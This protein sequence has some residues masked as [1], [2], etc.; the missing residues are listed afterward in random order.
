MP[1]KIDNSTQFNSYTEDSDELDSKCMKKIKYTR[2]NGRQ[3]NS[4]DNQ[5]KEKFMKILDKQTQ[6]RVFK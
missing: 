6:F 5:S 4:N 1:Q 2:N 3:I